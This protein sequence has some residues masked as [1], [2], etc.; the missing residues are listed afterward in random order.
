MKR[1]IPQRT[2]L[3]LAIAAAFAPAHAEPIVTTA[4]VEVVRASSTAATVA[5]L[6]PMLVLRWG[7]AVGS[8]PDPSACRPSIVSGGAVT[9]AGPWPRGCWPTAWP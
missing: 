6:R 3:A 1:Q 2:L 4:T 7:S 8:T 5:I 9:E